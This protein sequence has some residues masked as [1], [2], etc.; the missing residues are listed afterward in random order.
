MCSCGWRCAICASTCA[1][2]LGPKESGTAIRKRPRRSPEGRIVSRATSISSQTLAAW[3][4]NVI[5]SSVRAAPRVVRA[6]SWTPSSVSSRM[7]RRLT[8]DLEIPSRRAA[9]ETPP[10]SATSTN[11][12]RSSISTVSVPHSATQLHTKAGYRIENRNDSVR[13]A[14]GAAVSACLPSFR[15]INLNRTH[16]QNGSRGSLHDFS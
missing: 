13:L 3:S 7:S 15:E 5:P 4:R 8:I 6:R 1:K 14:G 11:V 12:L 16:T 2:W 9:G 10:A